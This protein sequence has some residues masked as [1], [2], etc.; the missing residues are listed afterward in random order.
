MHSTP[1]RAV[2]LAL[3]TLLGPAAPALAQDAEPAP[4]AEAASETPAP[5]PSGEIIDGIAAQ[6]G[7]EVVL[8][9]EVD[10][11]A[12][13]IEPKVREQGGTDQDIAMLRSDILDKLIERKLIQIVAKR[14]EIEA[15]EF[16]IDD[17]VNSIA[18]END[19]TVE[20][21][22]KSVV[23]QGL[24]W[25]A[26]RAR[27]AEEV[28]QS[29]VLGGMVRPRATVEEQQIRRLYDQRYGAMPAAGVPTAPRRWPPR[30]W[31]RSARP[32]VPRSVP[33]R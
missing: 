3:L 9:S 10:R 14:A 22:Q 30:C 6:I 33:N 19:M 26:Y 4:A 16:E 18:R 23:A 20:E 8:V 1:W 17:A 28:V 11:V 15:T 24:T 32:T 21:M 13:P 5:A 7:T 31:T 27:L 2:A 29:K 12:R 25:E